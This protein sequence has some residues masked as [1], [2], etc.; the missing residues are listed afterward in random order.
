MATAHNYAAKITWTGATAGG[1]TS[2]QAYSRE[3]EFKVGDK[4]TLRGSADPHF[5]GDATLY[6]PEELLVVSLSTCHLLS[7]LAECARAGV[8]VV[9][10]EDDASGT[11][12]MKDRAIRFTDVLLKPRVTIAP[13]SDVDKAKAL[14][15][16]AHAECFIANS[17]NFPVRHEA[18]IVVADH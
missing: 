16:K 14:H 18:T 11:M 10:Y 2:Y 5:R 17:V 3:Y 9:A 7:Y 6:N 1:T 13:G 8:N 12:A 15:A 4:Q